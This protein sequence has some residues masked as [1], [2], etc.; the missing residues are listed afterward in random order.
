MPPPTISPMTPT[1]IGFQE[2]S[3][4]N[5]MFTGWP[6]TPPRLAVSRP[7]HPRTVRRDAA[8]AIRRA[9][10]RLL[11]RVGHL[12]DVA[13]VRVLGRPAG[14]AG[15]DADVLAVRRDRQRVERPQRQL[16]AVQQLA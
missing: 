11:H 13:V 7:R 12:E 1:Q 4:A 15:R 14:E 8:G 2:Y 16:L 9:A 6:P 3:V 5:T 10:G